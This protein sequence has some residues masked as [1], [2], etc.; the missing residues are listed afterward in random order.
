MYRLPPFP[1]QKLHD[2]KG[3]ID[4]AHVHLSVLGTPE[5]YLDEIAL[6]GMSVEG[7][8]PGSASGLVS[9][10]SFAESFP[11]IRASTSATPGKDERTKLGDH[12]V[13]KMK[14]HTLYGV[15]PSLLDLHPAREIRAINNSLYVYCYKSCSSSDAYAAITW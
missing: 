13:M 6:A 5:N 14:L 12:S 1:E 10:N 3:K 4:R 11:N 7:S 2:D 9:S 8:A 15:S